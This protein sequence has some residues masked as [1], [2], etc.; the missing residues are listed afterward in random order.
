MEVCKKCKHY[1]IAKVLIHHVA[2]YYAEDQS[3]KD[4]ARLIYMHYTIR[5]D[6]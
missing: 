4:W 3:T 2:I 6:V 1:K 5:P